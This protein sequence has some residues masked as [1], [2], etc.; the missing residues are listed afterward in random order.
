MRIQKIRPM[1]PISAIFLTVLVGG[2]LVAGRD[3][4]QTPGAMTA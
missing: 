4:S 2:I 3:N 1:F